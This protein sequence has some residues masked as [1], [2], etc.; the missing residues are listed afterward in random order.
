LAETYFIIDSEVKRNGSLALGS[1]LRQGAIEMVML[2]LEEQFVER[3]VVFLVFA[4]YFLARGQSFK[5]M[6]KDLLKHKDSRDDKPPLFLSAE[7]PRLR[8]IAQKDGIPEGNVS[9]GKRHS[10]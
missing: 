4:R 6:I 8:H 5:I 7:V 3:E 10:L 1:L 2:I 9:P